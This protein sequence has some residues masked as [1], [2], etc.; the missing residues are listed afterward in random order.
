[1]AVLAYTLWGLVALVAAVLLIAGALVVAA[2]AAPARLSASG[3]VH[4]FSMAYP[5]LIGALGSVPLSAYT[6]RQLP[7]HKL[8]VLIATITIV[9]GAVTI[10]KAIQLFMSN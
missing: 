4:D 2:L 7:V 9:L 6:V 10:I 5:L 3:E 1:M 8:T